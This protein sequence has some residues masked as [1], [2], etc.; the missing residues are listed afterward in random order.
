MS[1]IV[2]VKH[3]KIYNCFRSTFKVLIT[4]FLAHARINS[5]SS[6][7]FFSQIFNLVLHQCDQRRNNQAY[8]FFCQSRNLV[9]KRFTTA[10]GIKAN[11]SFPSKTELMIS[12][13]N[14]RKES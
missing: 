1:L 2:Q 7:I 12:S 8:S 10:C 6:N 14:G 11:V 3:I 4:S 5:I 13:C 9:T